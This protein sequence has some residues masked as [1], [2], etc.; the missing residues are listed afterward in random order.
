MW[1]GLWRGAQS[2]DELLKLEWQIW[3]R[4][5]VSPRPLRVRSRH[6]SITS[7]ARASSVGDTVSPSA[8]AVF[9]LST[10]A[11]P[12]PPTASRGDI[13]LVTANT[14]G[15][16]IGGRQPVGRPRRCAAACDRSAR[17]RYLGEPRGLFIG[18]QVSRWATPRDQ[19][20]FVL[21]LGL[22]GCST[23][24]SMDSRRATFPV[25][26]PGHPARVSFI[27]ARAL[28]IPGRSTSPCFAIA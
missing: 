3:R 4:L 28:R 17:D 6:H 8:F 10:S 27:L 22:D 7:S 19:R 24:A 25:S 16:I 18:V 12:G 11:L 5:C 9:R 15:T 1:K 23:S 2:S 21:W 14:S 13:R 26:S 20:R